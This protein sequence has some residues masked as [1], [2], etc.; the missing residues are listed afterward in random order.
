MSTVGNRRIVLSDTVLV[1]SG[2]EAEITVDVGTD[3]ILNL[4]FRFYESEAD[5]ETKE[6]PNA[7]FTVE[8]DE[9]RGVMTFSNWVAPFGASITR[10]VD[11]AR[12]ERGEEITFLG[13]IV[14]L[15]EM[16]KVEFQLMIKEMSN[17]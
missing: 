6:K 12:S 16:Y 13:N 7:T 4:V 17:D 11:I 15:G 10:P 9:N 14:K 1:P 5:P 8:G 2:E 3:D